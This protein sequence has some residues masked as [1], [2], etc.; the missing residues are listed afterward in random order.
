MIVREIPVPEPTSAERIPRVFVTLLIMLGIL[1]VAGMYESWLMRSPFVLAA[2]QE[3]LRDP[4]VRPEFGSEVRFRAAI[5]WSQ[6]QA[7]TVYANVRGG[8]AYGFARFQLV[9][10]GERWKVARGEVRNVSE[11]HILNLT[12]VPG[13]VLADR[14]HG[15]GR[16]YLVVLGSSAT[17]EVNDLAEFL[18]EECGIQAEILPAMEPPEPAYH[19][20]RKQWIADMLIDAMAA[21]FPEIAGDADARIIG[22]IDDDIY[23]RGLNWDFTFNY[24]FANKYAVLQTLRL[25][26]GFSGHRPNAAIRTERLRKSAMKCLGMLYFGFRESRNP[27]SPMS[28]EGTLR[29]IDLQNSHYLL[30]DLATQA[31]SEYIDGQPC[32]S[33][34]SVNVGGLPRLEPIHACYEPYDVSRSSY[35]QINLVSGEFVTERNDVYNSGPLTFYLRRGYASHTYD[36]KVRAFGKGTWQNLDDTVW[37]TDPHTIQAINIAGVE[38]KRVT[39]GTGFSP[40]AK[41]VP[42]GN[43]GDFTGALLSWEGRW[44][45]ESPNGTVWHYR[46]CDPNSAIPCY[47]IDRTDAQGDRISV[48]RNLVG[49]IDKVSQRPGSDLPASYSHTWTFT[50]DGDRVQRIEDQNGQKAEYVYDPDSYLKETRTAIHQLRYDYDDAHRMTSI[51]DGRHEVGLHYDREGRVVEIDFATHPT[52]RIR[53]SGETVEVSAPAATYTLQLREKFFHLSHTD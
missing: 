46:G 40:S 8:E 2:S 33:F 41:Y 12:P 6:S 24:R 35:F 34:S 4:R 18:R 9:K 20:Q 23:P 52:Y 44:K 21:R 29:S 25:D 13:I 39:G 11:D 37:S 49:H 22:V 47:F 19:A 53:Y 1:V 42:A 48:E 38:F 32:L 51:I 17:G 15:K 27:D 31:R 5:G 14:L 36:G 7:A 30:S 16:L 50:Y 45:I 43:A 10:Q 26:P 3:M 28:Y